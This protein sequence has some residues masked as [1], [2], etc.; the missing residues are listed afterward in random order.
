M[1]LDKLNNR[2]IIEDGQCIR[3][4]SLKSALVEELTFFDVYSYYI[5]REYF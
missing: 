2:G 4:K 1:K 5:C 3:A